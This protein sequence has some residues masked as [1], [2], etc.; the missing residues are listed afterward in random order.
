MKK[1]TFPKLC[2]VDTYI[3]SISPEK[4]TPLWKV[5]L[6]LLGSILIAEGVWGPISE[7]LNKNGCTWQYR[8]Q[9]ILQHDA[10]G[11]M[12]SYST[13]LRHFRLLKCLGQL[14]RNGFF[15]YRW[16]YVGCICKFEKTMYISL[17][18]RIYIFTFIPG[19]K[20]CGHPLK[21]PF[22]ACFVGPSRFTL[23]VCKKLRWDDLGLAK[24]LATRDLHSLI[25]I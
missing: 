12:W 15:W 3:I 11:L 25:T 13:S 20:T 1:D 17:H 19:K 9:K 8:H 6:V 18:I 22:S 24:W 5:N 16:F 2:K 23:N 4:N 21:E 7:Y 14:W 10:G